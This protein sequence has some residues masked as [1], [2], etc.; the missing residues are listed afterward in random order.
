M[1]LGLPAGDGP[2]DNERFFP[3]HDRLGQRS[4]RRF[5]REILFASK[6]AQESS[7]LLRIVV[8]DRATQ[9]GITRFERVQYGALRDWTVDWELDLGADVSQCPKMWG[10]YDSDLQCCRFPPAS[11]ALRKSSDALGMAPFLF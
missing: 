4:V 10:Q 2:Y 1:K 3:R 11:D 9:H 7:A 6:E 8:A 5:V